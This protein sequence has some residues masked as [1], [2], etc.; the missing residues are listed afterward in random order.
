[1]RFLS[2]HFLRLVGCVSR[3][4]PFSLAAIVL[5]LFLL[6]AATSTAVDF[7]GGAC[8]GATFPISQ[9]DNDTGLQF[10]LRLP[11][12]LTPFLR[13]EPFYSNSQHGSIQREFAGFPYQRSGFDIHAGGANLA[14][15]ALAL[16]SKLEVLPYAGIGL[17]HLS[18][19]GSSA[20]HAGYN[21][22]LQAE[23]G[24]RSVL[25]VNARGEFNMIVD[26]GT[27]RKFA[28]VL[29]GFHYRFYST[30]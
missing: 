28:N 15:R 18:R 29:I 12:G 17:Y 16:G 27:S 7:W 25:A 22:G 4:S 30:P 23:V 2:F 1:M 14:V 6:S 3:P 24:F 20:S 21:F 11:I 10:G 8:I 19:P 9:D 13:I 26:N 5:A